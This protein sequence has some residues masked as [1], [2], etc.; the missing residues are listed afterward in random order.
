MTKRIF[1]VTVALLALAV[2]VP[3]F[4]AIAIAIKLDSSGPVFFRQE[5]VGCKGARFQIYK[6]RS[7]WPGRGGML[8]TVGRDSRITRVGAYLRRYKLD[9][10]PQLINVVFG[11][12]SL[13]GPRPEVPR[14]VALYPETMRTV[15]QS[16]RPG[17]T[18]PTSLEYHDES[19]LLDVSADPER[20]YTEEIL[21][22]KLKLYQAYVEHR[23]F[24]GD[25]LVLL[26][27]VAVVFA[28]KR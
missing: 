12:M 15:I 1:D 7:M 20:T 18:D 11:D 6:F 23:S 26:R 8:L 27:T 16:I 13:V 24:A 28:R 10:L 4:I 2:L 17:I 3:L 21:P 19:A 22:T 14:Y 25:L 9:E 5:R